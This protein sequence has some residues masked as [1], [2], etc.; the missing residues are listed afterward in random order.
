MCESLARQRPGRREHANA[1]ALDILEANDIW[2][3]EIPFVVAIGLVD[4]EWPTRANST[5]P[6][7]LQHAILTG[8]GPA[9]RLTPQTAWLAGRDLDQFHDTLTA[10][11]TGIIV[12]RHVRDVDGSQQTRSPLLDHIDFEP[13]SR[14]ARQRLLSADRALPSEIESMLPEETPATPEVTPDA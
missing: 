9:E 2:G 8:N 12:T 5:V 3:R 11:T 7:E 6:P 14:D 13:I 10:A 4:G 1:R